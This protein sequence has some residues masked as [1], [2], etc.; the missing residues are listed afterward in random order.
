MGQGQGD[1]AIKALH[2]CAKTGKWLH[3]QNVHLVTAWLST[4]E[5]ELSTIYSAT[6]HPKFRLWLTSEA[7]L[8]FPASLLQMSLKIT[9]EAP[10]GTHY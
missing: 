8:K 7:H 4:L 1:I 10:P 9:V 5:K 6:P 2:D 3:L